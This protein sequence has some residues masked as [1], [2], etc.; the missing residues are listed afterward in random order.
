MENS[1]PA[2]SSA[3]VLKDLHP[4]EMSLAPGGD[5]KNPQRIENSLF[6]MLMSNVRICNTHFWKY[7]DFG[8]KFDFKNRSGAMTSLD[9]RG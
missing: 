8:K 9:M 3:V 2:C 1:P 7:A 4:I 6:S 5:G